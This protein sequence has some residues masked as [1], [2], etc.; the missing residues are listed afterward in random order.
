MNFAEIKVIEKGGIRHVFI[1]GGR[2][3]KCCKSRN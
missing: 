3:E 2:T 1:D